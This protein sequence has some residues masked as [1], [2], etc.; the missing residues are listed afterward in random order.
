MNTNDLVITQCFLEEHQSKQVNHYG[1]WLGW[2]WTADKGYSYYRAASAEYTVSKD[3]GSFASDYTNDLT[4]VNGKTDTKI[5]DPSFGQNIVSIFN[6]AKGKAGTYN[7]FITIGFAPSDD[8]FSRNES[9][10]A[11]TRIYT[12]AGKRVLTSLY[13]YQPVPIVNAVFDVFMTL[14]TIANPIG[15]VVMVV[16][17]VLCIFQEDRR[18]IQDMFMNMF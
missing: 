3:N 17:N 7:R 15:Y 4:L 1:G 8:E 6:S 2:L 13:D 18:G 14:L 11:K 10:S 16:D 5:K 9:I 12:D